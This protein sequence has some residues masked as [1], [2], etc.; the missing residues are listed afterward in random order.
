MDK[1]LARLSR[2]LAPRLADWAAVDLRVG[3]RQVHRVAVTGPE[4][5]EA[6]QEDWRGHLPPVGEATHS[7]L[8]QVLNEGAPVL[9]KR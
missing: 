1:A 4:S 5:R 6:R 2:G 8:V 9:Q 7:P 3:S